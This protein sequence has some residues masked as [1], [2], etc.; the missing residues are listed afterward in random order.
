MAAARGSENGSDN[1]LK[2]L[3]SLLWSLVFLLV[4]VLCWAGCYWALKILWWGINLFNWFDLSWINLATEWL[5]GIGA[6]VMGGYA[7]MAILT[8]RIKDTNAVA[9]RIF[10][11][12]FIGFPAGGLMLS[13]IQIRTEYDLAILIGFFTLPIGF[14]LRS[15]EGKGT[16]DN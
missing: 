15:W 2:I 10:P 12:L 3:L 13:A 14:E 1:L 6:G 7:A 16:M 8:P 5:P 9:F 4:M 11:Y